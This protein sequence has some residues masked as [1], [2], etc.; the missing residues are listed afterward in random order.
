[1]KHISLVFEDDLQREDLDN[2]KTIRG[3]LGVSAYRNTVNL[4][5][6]RLDTVALT[7]LALVLRK[8]LA[9][10]GMPVALGSATL[11]ETASTAHIY[12]ALRSE[13]IA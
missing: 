11:D 5:F 6:R 9:H 1:M 4:Y 8:H 10:T 12:A 13:A 2:L 3:C 7:S